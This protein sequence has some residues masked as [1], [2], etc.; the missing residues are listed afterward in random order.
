MEAEAPEP[1]GLPLDYKI[2]VRAAE[3][4]AGGRREPS[5]ALCGRCNGGQVMVRQAPKGVPGDSVTW[6][7]FIG[8]P[9]PPDI[10]QGGAYQE[11]TR[12]SLHDMAQ[13]ALDID[14]R[15][16]FNDRSYL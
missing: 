1:P 10:V 7:R 11:Q 15:K 2:Y 5:A 6:G 14:P 8:R 12:M 4:R 3:I 16:A 13:I 9:V